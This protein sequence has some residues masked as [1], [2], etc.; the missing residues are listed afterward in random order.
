[1]MHLD[2]CFLIDLLR[3]TARE[4]PGP[5]TEF[6]ETLDS[7]EILGVS[8]HVLCELR[9]GAELSRRPLAEHEALDQLVSG[10]LVSYPDDRF[11]HTY[12]RLLAA[13]SVKGRAVSA[14]N[15]LI[16]S[17][18]LNDDAPLVTRNVKDFNRMPGLRVM[19]Y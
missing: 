5:A 13:T 17:A 15:L 3:E 6:L 7:T 4:R 19:D 12:G 11:A 1:M 2:S 9:A 16:A 8:A 14:M 10:L 18:A